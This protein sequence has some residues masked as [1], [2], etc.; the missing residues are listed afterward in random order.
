MP[1]SVPHLFDTNRRRKIQSR[2]SSGESLFLLEHLS[3]EVSDRITSV[4][5]SFTN[6][7]I[8]AHP[9]LHARVRTALASKVEHLTLISD[10]EL[11]EGRSLDTDDL[12]LAP[13]TQD[14]VAIIG[15]L[16]CV[17]DLPGWFHQI[18]NALRPD[19]LMI[20]G[21]P[22]GETLASFRHHFTALESDLTGG[23]ALRIH[24]FVSLHDL[25]SLLQRAGF[26]LPVVDHDP[27]T[28]RYRS[29]GRLLDDL[30]HMGEANCLASRHPLR[31]SVLMGL[32]N[33]FR[34]H[35]ADADGKIPILFD[36]LFASGWAPAPHQP[37][38]LKPGSATHR[39]ADALRTTEVPLKHND[40]E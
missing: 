13:Q 28:V 19:G 11:G 16:H 22:G 34:A 18:K 26:A 33:Y 40:P 20:A 5:R 15:T 24:P 12:A 23:V 39:L 29:I 4:N 14:L 8:I 10:F 9:L 1:P 17:N 32:D 25:A 38:P 35:A 36:F 3:D 37:Q 30:R 27:L 2:M 6:G 21:F 31:R 7:L